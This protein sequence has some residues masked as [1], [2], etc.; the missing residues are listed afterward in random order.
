MSQNLRNYTKAVYGFDH[1]IRTVPADRWDRPSPCDGWTAKDV[2]L[3]AA[4]VVRMVE[5]AARG[6]APVPHPDD[7]PV[8]AEADPLAAWSAACDG[9][10]EA[11]DHDGV[12]HK[13]VPSP[14]GEMLLDNLIGILLVDAVTHTWDLARAVGGDERLSPELV[15]VAHAGVTPLDEAIRGAGYFQ[16]KIETA[17]GDDAQTAFL[18]F[19]GRKV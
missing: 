19:L 7:L 4:G 1:V 6:A 13:L 18:K 10:L 3:H 8:P 16:A 11:L 14:F 2:A 9:V 15:T 5:A 12:L 17:P